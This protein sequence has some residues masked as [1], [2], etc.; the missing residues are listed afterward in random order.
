[1]PSPTNLHTWCEREVTDIN[2]DPL[3]H[4]EAIYDDDRTGEPAFLLVRGG[5]FG[6]KMHFA[7]V[8]GARLEGDVIRLAAD[9]DQV[10]GAP[11]V[12]ADDHL[13]PEEEQRLFEHYGLDS[14]PD[15]STSVIILS[16]WMVVE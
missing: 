13:S 9:A 7:P 6:N 5:R 15:G 8:E 1:M 11:R 4:A 3:G 10:N 16:R 14:A 12:S 2:G